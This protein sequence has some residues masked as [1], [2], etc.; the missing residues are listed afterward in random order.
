MGYHIIL[1]VKCQ[2]LPEFLPFIKEK[3]LRKDTNDDGTVVPTNYAPLLR[4]WNRLAIGPS[5]Y[6]YDLSADGVFTC[7]IEKKPYNHRGDLWT[8]YEEFLKHIIVPISS[9]ILS[10]RISEDD[11]YMRDEVYTDSQ[12]RNIRFRLDEWM[13]Y[14]EHVYEDDMII[15]TRVVW[16]RPFKREMELDVTRMFR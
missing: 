4:I 16:K 3:Y 12:L 15:E 6:D 11:V 2:I 10:C 1:Q 5:F 8:D 9:K 13:D 7:H 14:V